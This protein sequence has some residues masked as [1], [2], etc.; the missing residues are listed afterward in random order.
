[1]FDDRKEFVYQRLIFTKA[2][3]VRRLAVGGLDT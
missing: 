1:M 2:F 3:D